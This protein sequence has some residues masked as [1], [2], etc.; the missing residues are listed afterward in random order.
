MY[1]L[2]KSKKKKSKII[3]LGAQRILILTPRQM[4][5]ASRQMVEVCVC[6][7]YITTYKIDTCVYI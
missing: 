1:R 5:R 4:W 2:S 3:G 6:V 7:H